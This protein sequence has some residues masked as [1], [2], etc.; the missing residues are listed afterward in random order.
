VIV[1][2]QLTDAERAWLE[3]DERCWTRARR[4]ADVHAQLDLT[5]IYHTLK[6]FERS[7]EERLRRGLRYGRAGAERR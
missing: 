6:N 5:D 7:P 4:I 3:A 1:N 2:D